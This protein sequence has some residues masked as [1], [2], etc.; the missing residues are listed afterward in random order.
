MKTEREIE[1]YLQ[2]SVSLYSEEELAIPLYRRMDKEAEIARS[3][4]DTGKMER[5]Y[6]RWK[7][8][9][10]VSISIWYGEISR[11]KFCT[12]CCFTWTVS[13]SITVIL[14]T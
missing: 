1:V 9:N 13:S 5:K 10:T 3:W 11:S 8:L 2:E 7:P 12:I 6:H 4:K 14:K